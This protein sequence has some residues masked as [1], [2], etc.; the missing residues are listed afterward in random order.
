M[1]LWNGQSWSSL[2]IALRE[3]GSSRVPSADGGACVRGSDHAKMVAFSVSHKPSAALSRPEW[4]WSVNG[5]FSEALQ[6]DRRA[7]TGGVLVLAD[8]RG[9]PVR[10]S[11][12]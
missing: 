6:D 8:Q 11:T 3:Q 10:R 2:L 9:V 1:P 4:E 12:S 7:I 5:G